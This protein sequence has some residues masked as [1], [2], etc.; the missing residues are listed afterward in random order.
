MNWQYTVLVGLAG[1]LSLSLAVLT[2]S[3]R[4]AFGA[5]YFILLMSA[6]SVWAFTAAIESMPWDTQSKI[7]WSQLS[8]IGIV[9]VGPLWVLL[10]MSYSQRLHRWTRWHILLLW[11]IPLVT[12]ML[13]ATNRHHGLIWA[14][15]APVSNTPGAL[16]VYERGIGFWIHAVYSY[17]ALLAG[18]ILLIGTTLSTT[19]LHRRQ[20]WALL[21]GAILP[22][23]GNL[24]YLLRLY[25]LPELDK[26]MIGFAL[27]GLLV[28]YGLFR[29]RL[30][31]LVPVA[32]AA[33]IEN[34]PDGVL[35][36]DEQDRLVDINP[37]ACHLLDREAAQIV[38][39]P[40]TVVLARWSDLAE[41][42]RG[43]H[44]VQTE[45][46][47]GPHRW[48]DL[49]VSALYNRQRQISGRLVVLRDVTARKQ[50][51]QALR[52][53]EANFRAF[54]ET[55]TDIIVVG[56][57]DGHIL[58][59]NSAA[60]KTL[61]YSVAELVGM[62][63]LDLHPVNK[64]AEA[65]EILTAM[66]QGERDV[67]PLPLA[68]RDG[69]LVPVETRVWRGRWDGQ[70]C[71]FGL[72]KNLTAEQEAQQRFER[73]FR[74]NPTLMALSVLPGRQFFDVNNAFLEATGYAREEVIG[75]TAAA[76]GL[77]VHP[78][79]QQKIAQQLLAQGHIANVETQVRCNDGTI[80]DGLF[81]G[82]IISSQGH[83]YFLT[84]MIDATERKQMEQ[85]LRES[86]RQYRELYATAQRQMHELALL[87]QVRTT[88]AR[89]LDLPTIFHDVVEALAETFGYTL[90]SLYLRQDDELVLQHQ[91]GYTQ[92]FERIP[93]TKG[94]T[95]QVVRTGEPVLLRDVHT[96]PA[97]LEAVPNI[98]S[99]V[100][101]PLIDQGQTVGIL[102]VE[103]NDPTAL[104]EADLALLGALGEHIT[105]AMER[106][107]LY[108]QV[109]ERERHLEE[110]VQ[111]RTAALR[112]EIAER[113]QVQEALRESESRFRAIY[114]TAN[115]LILAHNS[116][117]KVIY[118]NPYACRTL[119]YQAE[120]L[121]GQRIRPLF[122]EAEL[123]KAR[124]LTAR[125]MADPDFQVE[126]FEQYL[127]K[128]DGQRVLISWNV[129]ALRDGEGNVGGIL[130]IGQDITLRKQ[131]EE[132]LEQHR[133]H[134]EELVVA[135]TTELRE[136]QRLLEQTVGE[137][138]D[139]E[140]FLSTLHD[141]THAALSSPDLP[142]MLQILADRTG[143]LFGA[144]GCYLTLWDEQAEVTLPTAAYG[145]LREVYP[146]RRSDPGE[147]TMTESVLR[148]G[149]PL[150]AEDVMNTP[151][152]SPRIATKYPTRSLLALPLVVGERKLGAALV[153]Y[154]IPHQFTEEE[155][156]R[157]EQTARQISLAVAK[158]RLY[159]ELQTYA[160][161]LEERVRA[162]TA[163]LQAQ[164]V[165]L[166]AILRSVDD[167]IF[168]TDP[169]RRILYVNP[170]FTEQIG[171]T[172]TDVLGQTV[173]TLG[174]LGDFEALLPSIM[175]LLAQGKIW[176]GEVLGRRKDGRM[177]D[178]ALTITPVHSE[179]ELL[180]G[181]VFTHRDI[182]QAKD[183]ERA[184]SQFITNVSHQLLTPL[185]PLKTGVYLLKHTL[186]SEKQL[187]QL[188]AM[189]AGIDWLVQ[190]VQD[191]LEISVLDSSKRSQVWTTVS[192]A[193]I[194][195]EALERHQNRAQI[196][197]I[198]LV[199]EPAPSD[200]PAIR[201]DALRLAQALSEVVEN[202]VAFTPAGGH[203]TI[204]AQTAAAAGEDWITVAVQDTGPG[205]AE[206]ELPRIFERFFRGSP[207]ESGHTAG[208]G[209][210]L[211]IAQRIVEA[212]GG[213]VTVAST[214]GQ[215][216]T[217]TLWL[218]PIP[219]EGGNQ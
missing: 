167:V 7:L 111:A 156:Q 109:R 151:Y 204:M 165:R 145:P 144:D 60:A 5:V 155:I 142:T 200:L 17:A 57:P 146:S 12:L 189:E 9:N 184:R 106:A 125:L 139:R 138:Q 16:L 179:A 19:Q 74:N 65:T 133:V 40:I 117:G 148:A 28:A 29:L 158:S 83:D 39:Q 163:E 103:S 169:E 76:L 209:L 50:T 130:G 160:G 143:E 134:L 205:I 53:S 8:Y 128:K 99:E 102:N 154:N 210:G 87:N 207:A 124:P 183:L 193:D 185:T 85:A 42:Y 101:V 164:Y 194:M 54:F 70:D 178:A 161:Q 126:G 166:D 132:E 71:I 52:E 59:T 177:Y 44:Q 202:A 51:E 137:L 31:N 46:A 48:F 110:L 188:E 96:D 173:C 49:N 131:M 23:I 105:I 140:R 69:T 180:T 93:V 120:E 191:I 33:L 30:F 159:Q 66:F 215:G 100:C 162:R 115:V 37:A 90:V 150:V 197:G 201:G 171:Y 58:F 118:I 80:R 152:L 107:R 199:V 72:S 68:H 116:E 63:I 61:G 127:L 41:R 218:R 217:F 216:S 36:L 168:M 182:S 195:R 64:R 219:P 75:R 114:N 136:N 22:W 129:T 214:V 62:H 45:I 2:W 1:M 213:H 196:A 21:L 187:Q 147:A 13:V 38:G 212:H 113:A 73:L 153:A 47:V 32:R 4:R 20:I 3:H 172:S 211:S 192:L 10:A 108:A 170:A 55:I 135:R 181:Y 67:C 27:G 56:A 112:R 176:H 14:H 208:T 86:E 84:V 186:Q 35:V 43:Q 175:P 24:W 121:L 25:P 18:T 104:T 6:V 174:L 95:G 26:T 119:G 198:T 34:L 97:F 11:I 92:V 149:H 78:E 123:Q 98:S 122:E 15:V 157:G 88:L 89:E 94:V 82:E 91:V 79:E 206:E 77:F 203:V 190:L 81:W 141:I